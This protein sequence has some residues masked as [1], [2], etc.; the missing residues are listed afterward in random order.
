MKI[1]ISTLIVL[2]PAIVFAQNFQN[3]SEQDMQ[4]MMEQGQKMQDCMQNVDQSQL[5]ALQKRSEEF[6]AELRSLCD[7]GK[8][9]KVQKKAI[10][11][12]KEVM[13]NPAMKQMKKCGE[14]AQ[15]MMSQMP[16]MPFMDEDV[17]YSKTHVCD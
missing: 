3:M 9:D 16:Q 1:V 17:D 6:Q 12:S 10:S 8:R 15:G 4:K 14:L 13:N 2:L 5:E 11:Y 7:A